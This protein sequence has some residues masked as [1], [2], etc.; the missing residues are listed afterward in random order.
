M[1]HK[2][3][4][5]IILGVILVVL[6]ADVHAQATPNEMKLLTQNTGWALRYGQLYWTTDFGHDWRKV[7]PPGASRGGPIDIADVF[8]LDTSS[9]WALLREHASGGPYGYWSF[10]LAHTGDAGTSW[11]M[12]PVRLPAFPK[13]EEL[14]GGAALDFVNATQG[15]INLS[16]MS[17]PNWARGLLYSTQDAGQTWRLVANAPKIAARVRF[18]TPSEGWL[19]G[20]PARQDL[21]STHDGGS[22]WTKIALQAPP[23]AGR[24]VY[25]TYQLPVFHSAKRGYVSVFYSGGEGDGSALVL[26]ETTDG[27]LRW[28]PLGTLTY[29]ED[30]TM[31]Q[32]V[33]AANADSELLSAR[34]SRSG[35]LVLKTVRPGRA[36]SETTGAAHAIRQT[37]SE[38][39]FQGGQTGWAMMVGG[40]L[41]S[42]SDRG[43]TWTDIT[44]KPYARMSHPQPKPN[45]P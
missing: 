40:A 14:G 1:S 36:A 3:T 34:V 7:T 44:P 13:W 32:V 27:G 33:P 45:R 19:A 24:A 8:F 22:T 41:Y 35:Q 23:Q 16:L 21:Y 38:L 2:R 28:R 11:S 29:A 42:T 37:V 39:S 26:F 9:G 10:E 4:T 15:W 5:A 6:P 43:A 31:G 18:V 17:G 12:S 20:G 30:G 25:P